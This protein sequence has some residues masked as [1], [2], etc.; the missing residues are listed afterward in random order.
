MT[1]DRAEQ[2]FRDIFPNGDFS[3]F[4]EIY[5]F[6]GEDFD[7]ALWGYGEIGK[8]KYAKE[9]R[10]LRIQMIKKKYIVR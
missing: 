5:D 9:K 6:W 10:K 7:M 1:K 4:C 2:I 8:D 3:R